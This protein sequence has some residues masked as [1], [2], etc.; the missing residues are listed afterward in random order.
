MSKFLS[1]KN[2]L[3]KMSD[4]TNDQLV[5][6]KSECMEN[7][8]QDKYQI[9]YA[10][11]PWQYDQRSVNLSNQCSL[12]YPTMSLSELKDLNIG[13]IADK[14]CALYLWTSNPML[15]KSISLIEHWG[16]EY[17]TVFKVWRK[18]NSDGTNVMVPGWWSRSS[19]ELLLVATKGNPLSKYK[20][21]N[22]V[23][24]QEYTSTRG[25][26]SEKPDEIRESIENFMN[27]EKRIELF[28]RKIVNNWDAWG[29]E[30]P[31]FFYSCG[32][33]ITYGV[34]NR[35]IGIQVHIEQTPKK[36]NKN[37]VLSDKILNNKGIPL[38]HKP[39]CNCFVCKKI[40][41]K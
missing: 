39:N 41:L 38:G 7:F 12:H 15:P 23:E 29:L 33:D 2:E 9:I 37:K 35:S 40:R 13:L 16:F 30:I 5:Q 19:T 26:H 3:Y 28:S 17:K 24:L 25:V 1:I 20:S 11:P 8:P 4:I 22:H 10:D 14:H 31:G 27:V 34:N 21:A 18:V 6:W 36:R 32:S